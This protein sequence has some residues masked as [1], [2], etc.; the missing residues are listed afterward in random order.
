[1]SQVRCHP[2]HYPV[3]VEADPVPVEADPVESEERLLVMGVHQV[4]EVRLGVRL[5]RAQV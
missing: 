3:P 5:C 1:M 2:G 4:L